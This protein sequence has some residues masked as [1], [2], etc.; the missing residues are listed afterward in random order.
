MENSG[1]KGLIRANP[2]QLLNVIQAEA[3][4]KGVMYV[5]LLISGQK[6]VALVE[7]RAT[8]NFISMRETVRLSLKLTQDDS[9]LKVLNC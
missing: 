2:L 7:S 1:T 4:H 9:K 5:E 6:I 3:T 8:H